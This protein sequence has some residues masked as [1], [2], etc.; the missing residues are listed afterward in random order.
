MEYRFENFT[1]ATTTAVSHLRWRGGYVGNNEASNPVVEFIIKIYGSTANGFYPDLANPYLKKYTITGNANQ[2]AAEMLAGVQMYDYSVTLPTSFQA[3]AGVGYWLQIEASQWVY[4]L[5][6]GFATGTG[7]NSAHYRRIGNSY[8]SGAGDLA[9]SLSADAPTTFTIA[10]ISSNAGG[11]GVGGAGTFALDAVVNLTATPMPGYAFVNW[12]EAGDEV[13]PPATHQFSAT[14]N[15][16]LVATFQPAYPLTLTSS[17]PTM[18]TVSGA[19]TYL[20]GTSA[21]A[22][23]TAKAGYIFLNWTENGTPISTSPTFTFTILAARNLRAN[24]TAGFNVTASPSFTP[25]GSVGGAGGYPTG[26]NVTL[27]AT[28]ADGYKFRNWTETGAVV[29]TSPILSFTSSANRTLVANFI[30]IIEIATTAGH[31]LAISWP[32]SA[33]GW[34]L[35]ESTDL[36]AA[37]WLPSALPVTINGTRNEVIL[38]KAKQA[39]MEMEDFLSSTLTIVLGCRVFNEKYSC[40][41]AKFVKNQTANNDQFEKAV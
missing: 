14:A 35:Q 16:T 12:T 29:D 41:P 39:N 9:I 13:S 32:A 17:S 38:R 6:W 36:G 1:L 2:T 40:S 25:G 22:T 21:T 7:G 23:A 33:T 31:G 30:P 28:P 27:T 18:G 5:T 10:A 3:E 37:S 26:S 24:F 20:T 15:R 19:G 4:P 8:F 11:G 34:V